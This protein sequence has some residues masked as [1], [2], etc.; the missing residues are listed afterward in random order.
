M[1]KTTSYQEGARTFR[2]VIYKKK[3]NKRVFTNMKPLPY[4]QVEHGQ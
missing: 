4:V 3:K 1:Q 2:R